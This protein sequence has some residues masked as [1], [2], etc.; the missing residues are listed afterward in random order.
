MML[1]F[2]LKVHSSLGCGLHG[3]RNIVFLSGCR[4][5]SAVHQVGQNRSLAEPVLFNI[6]VTFH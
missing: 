1:K 3:L 6:S 4:R 5:M 2:V